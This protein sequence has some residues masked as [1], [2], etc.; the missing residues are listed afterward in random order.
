M[1]HLNKNEIESIRGMSYEEFVSETA[2]DKTLQFQFDDL[3]DANQSKY[4]KGGGK[5]LFFFCLFCYMF[6]P[7]IAISFFAYKYDN[8]FLL[9]GIPISYIS[10]FLAT[11]KKYILMAAPLIPM[12]IN[13]IFFNG[14]HFSDYATFFY[15]CALWGGFFYLLAI[16]Y[17]TDFAKTEIMKNPDLFNELSQYGRIFFLR[18]KIG[19]SNEIGNSEASIMWGRLKFEQE[20]FQGAIDA[21]DKAIELSPNYGKAYLNRALAKDK[22]KDYDGAISD[23][24]IAIALFPKN[25]AAYIGRGI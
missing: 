23:F 1:A 9:I 14:F 17:E 5:V 13:W 16:E 7:V 8:W 6:F 3:V 4:L 20:D 25:G 18:K 15:C 24:D 21:F 2:T 12:I 11:R 19:D 10:T 22:L